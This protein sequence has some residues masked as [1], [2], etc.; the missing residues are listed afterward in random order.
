MIRC[1]RCDT[2]NPSEAQFCMRCGT[3]LLRRCPVCGAPN[4]Q[5]AHFCLRCGAP[6]AEARGTERRV[7]SVLFA[8]LAGSTPLTRSLDP[9]PMRRIVAEYFTTMREEIQR[10]GGTVEKFIGDAVM[11]VFGLPV[12][13]EDDSERALRAGVAMQARMPALNEA[14]AADLRLRIG[15]STGEVVADPRAAAAGQFMV[16]GEVVNLA[17]RLQQEAPPEAIVTDERT[18]AATRK[19][20][21]FTPLGPAGEGD[22]AGAP[23]WRVLG[24]TE[25]PEDTRLRAPMVG[26]DDEVQ[27]LLALYRRV[28]DGRRH[29]LVTIIGAAGVGKTRLVEELVAALGRT[30]E[31]PQVLRGRCPAYGEG[32]T[33]WPLAEMLKQECR[34]RDTDSA[35]AVAEKLRRGILAVCEPVLGRPESE[36]IAADLATVLGVE[37]FADEESRWRERLAALKDAVESR[38]G[39]ARDPLVGERQAAGEAVR[40]AFRAFLMAK[41]QPAPVLLIFEDLHW[42]EESLLE[43]V[44]S[45]ALRGLDAPV[46]TLCL[47]RPELLERHP[48]WGARI[49]NYTSV[50]LSPLPPGVSRRLISELLS[51]EPVPADVRD[52]IVAKAEGNPFFI[53][54]ILRMLIDVEVA[55]L[56]RGEGGWRWAKHPREIRIP[57]TIHSLLAS[58]LD[59]MPALEKRVIQDASV[60]GRIFWLGALLASDG[61]N[62]AEAAAALDRLQERELVE[63][64]AA[65]SLAGEREFT[66][67]HALIREVAYASL[68]KAARSVNHLRFARW[69]EATAADT[70]E[71]FLEV[72]AHHYEQAWRYRF[73]TGDRAPDL[74]RTAIG[75]L[76]A[77]GARARTLGTLPEARR[78]HERALAVLRNAGLEG[79]LPLLLE[80]LTSRSEVVK[81]MNLPDVVLEDTETILHHAPGL[82]RD[83]LLA[84]AWL[85]R[86]FA[87]YLHGRL[88][89]AD[90]A[91]QRAQELFHRLDDRQGEAEA[92]EILGAI[93]E[94]LRD[95]LTRAQKAYRRA[96]DL[97]RALAD[98]QGIARTLARL[99]R[100]AINIGDLVEGRSALTEALD[101]ARRHGEPTS[102]VRSLMGLAILAH[103]TGDSPESVR[104]HE[105]ALAVSRKMGDALGQAGVRR[106]LGMHYLRYGRV[107]EAERE[108]QAARTV[109]REATNEE[110]EGILR[111]LAEVSLARGDLLSAAEYA[112]GAEA[113][114]ADTDQITRATVMATLAKVRAAQGRKEEAEALFGRSLKILD[115]NEYRIDHALV[116]LRYGEGLL[117]MGEAARARPIL[118][119]TRDLFAQMGATRFVDEIASKLEMVPT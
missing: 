32:L 93:T 30:G 13:H 60:A 46:L 22:F 19:V 20:A 6:L 29:H 40:R 75:A 18:Y 74:A 106:H 25:R 48:D 65:S 105:E 118:E 42:A 113:A 72:L 109:Y 1:P 99:G 104:L 34:I 110:M 49:R 50:S 76:R 10:F 33:Y 27:F 107:D 53:E 44:E 21:A 3:P 43:L 97:Y 57:D 70:A 100:T 56:V 91:L 55:G 69:L 111:G 90:D 117:M 52:A 38:A 64:R 102:E 36:Q 28:V 63:E 62:P 87:E 96:L 31:P 8:D 82:G 45:L 67:K 35:A 51:G 116:L 83:D 115:A 101:L 68:P 54:E 114:T 39:P 17:A 14:L 95:K 73:E 58:R 77:A 16:T 47:V 23:R 79:D 26:R 9:E 5:D 108:L 78:L 112:E 11:A 92:L 103:L 24:L 59:Q 81:W 7:V 15:I 2:E 98:G 41:A 88:A 80:L 12:A 85:N 66:F 94:N 4:P 71:K 89:P 61:L 86:A 37:V 84:R 119:R